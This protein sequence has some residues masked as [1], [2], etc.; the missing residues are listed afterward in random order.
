MESMIVVQEE[1]VDELFS[2]IICC[3]SYLF[4]IPNNAASMW[5]IDIGN[6]KA[7]QIDIGI[8]EEEKKIQ[9]KFKTAYL[10]HNK[11][12]LF[13]HGIN[14]CVV[15]D[16]DSG[17]YKR[18]SLGNE[19]MRLSHVMASD[20]E[21]CYL[22][23]LNQDMIMKY[24]CQSSSIACIKVHLDGIHVNYATIFQNKIVLA[25]PNDSLLF[26]DLKSW[27]TMTKTMNVIPE[28]YKD[29]EAIYRRIIRNG[30]T[31]IIIPSATGTLYY[32]RNGS[33]YSEIIIDD[34][35][36][37]GKKRGFPRY[38]FDLLTDDKL[39]IQSRVDGGVCEID[40]ESVAIARHMPYIPKEIIREI[41]TNVLRIK[42]EPMIKEKKDIILSDFINY[43]F[44]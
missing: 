21:F 27:E 6:G 11:L 5:R 43:V 4:L 23:V 29:D 13:G 35:C 38:E 7:T 28:E 26:I 9:G 44:I 1:L 34:K 16:M 36:F 15:Y 30:K 41:S 24:D 3:D 40:L 19:K 25:V 31:T 33:D 32:S 22:P 20:E 8:K 39:Y 18:V 2:K 42:K 10:W 14:A 12:H 37:R 17:N